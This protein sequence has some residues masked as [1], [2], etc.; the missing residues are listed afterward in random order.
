MRIIAGKYRGARLRAPSGLGTRPTTAKV[1]EAAFNVLSHG[2]L[3]GGFAGVRVLDLF[4]GSGAMGLEALSRG[5]EFCMFIESDPKAIRA[6]RDNA[7]HLKLT[8]PD[9]VSVRRLDAS[10][11]PTSA[12]S[13][14]DIV[15]ADPPYG[16]ELPEK[17]MFTAINGGWIA[18]DAIIVIEM[19]SSTRLPEIDAL[20]LLEVRN[21]KDTVLLFLKNKITRAQGL[22]KCLNNAILSR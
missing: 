8:D 1:R 2:Y 21:Y 18:P 9:N 6:I 7:M 19:C 22:L 16:L 14:Y 3:P 17:S 5:A 15:F 20:E 4:A 13:S 11:L 10:R 12:S